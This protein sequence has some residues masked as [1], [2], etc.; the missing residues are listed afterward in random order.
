[1]CFSVTKYSTCA[2]CFKSKSYRVNKRALRQHLI[3][4]FKSLLK[5]YIFFK[6]VFLYFYG[7][8][9]LKTIFKIF[10]NKKYLKKQIKLSLDE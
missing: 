5:K 4:R 7:V 2:V 1:M 8:L 9:M 10:L 6:L 3:L